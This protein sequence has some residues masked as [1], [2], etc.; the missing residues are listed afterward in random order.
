LRKAFYFRVNII[1][2]EINVDRI[3]MKNKNELIDFGTERII[4]MPKPLQ[5]Y[6]CLKTKLMNTTN[7]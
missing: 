6:I 2:T 1:A 3:E 7:L 4:E 5:E